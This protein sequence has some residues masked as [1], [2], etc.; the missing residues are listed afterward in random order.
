MKILI[1][2]AGIAGLAMALALR[3]RNID[4]DVV[5]RGAAVTARGAGMYLPGNAVRALGQ[6]GVFD[7]VRATGS[8]IDTQRI[9]DGSGRLLNEV[10]LKAFW[11][12]CGGCLSLSRAALQGIL[13][14]ALGDVPIRFGLS[15]A[16][17]QQVGPHAD[18]T[19]GDGSTQIYDL[20]I[21]ADGIQSTVRDLAFGP[22]APRDLGI[23][24][25]R[26]IIDNDFGLS[27][28]TA[29]L[30]QKRTLLAIPVEAGKLYIYGDVA[31]AEG[32]HDRV[33]PV[34]ILRDLFSS[35]A[36]PL[37]PI[38]ESLDAAQPIHAARLREIPAQIRHTGSVVLIGDAA[39]TT[40]PSM[41]QGAGMALEDALVLAE[42]LAGAASVSAAL[43]AFSARRLGRVEWVQKQSHKRDKVRT[44][45]GFLRNFA[46]SRLGTP[47]YAK[48]FTPLIDAI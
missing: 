2:G 46:L 27:G 47:L 35:F 13:Q 16:G 31:A 28:W 19:F 3:A 17:I 29:M 33:E 4:C 45:P 8:A 40:S 24:C 10:D 5:E 48:A 1:A 26:T 42:T 22:E 44:L 39:H 9:F 36:A 43:E 23:A 30:G 32:A 34:R 18:V 7:H 25:W 41:A 14:D 6:L 21:G 37:R 20:V 38:V 15:L 11:Q 12:A